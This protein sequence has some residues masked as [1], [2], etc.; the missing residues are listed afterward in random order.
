[1]YDL[2]GWAWHSTP[3]SEIGVSGDPPRYDPARG[4]LTPGL[5]ASQAHVCSRGERVGPFARGS[6]RPR[7]YLRKRLADQIVWFAER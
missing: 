4:A 2:P 6:I 3:L 1:V 5:D 7:I